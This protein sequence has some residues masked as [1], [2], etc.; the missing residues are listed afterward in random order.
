MHQQSNWDLHVLPQKAVWPPG[1]EPLSRLCQIL[2]CGN[3]NRLVRSS[4]DEDVFCSFCLWTWYKD[5]QRYPIIM[6]YTLQ[7]G[8]PCLQNVQWCEMIQDSSVEVAA[9]SMTLLLVTACN[10]Y[11]HPLTL[12]IPELS[13]IPELDQGV[14]H[15]N[16]RLLLLWLAQSDMVM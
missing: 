15:L 8:F 5:N 3:T 6:I 1:R 11:G 12:T 13:T 4:S 7:Y 2:R 10:H 9:L 16:D 14:T